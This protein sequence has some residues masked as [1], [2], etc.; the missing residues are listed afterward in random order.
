MREGGMWFIESIFDGRKYL[1]QACAQITKSKIIKTNPTI[2]VTQ[3]EVNCILSAIFW[4]LTPFTASLVVQNESFRKS[5][6][7]YSRR[8]PSGNRGASI[9]PPIFYTHYLSPKKLRTYNDPGSVP[10]LRIQPLA[11]FLLSGSL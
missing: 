1:C 11:K 5:E 3:G 10:R 9:N 6:D 4:T 2:P 7:A 8:R